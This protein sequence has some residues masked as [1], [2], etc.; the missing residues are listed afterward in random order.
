MDAG[1]GKERQE[2]MYDGKDKLTIRREG[3]RVDEV[4]I[5]SCSKESKGNST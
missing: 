1:K 2:W 3:G 5:A 4:M